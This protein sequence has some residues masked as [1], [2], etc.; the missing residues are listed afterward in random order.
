MAE[1]F[2]DRYFRIYFSHFNPPKECTIVQKTVRETNRERT[3]E[4]QHE[5]RLEGPNV[6]SRI[7][8]S[9]FWCCGSGEK[10]AGHREKK[11]ESSRFK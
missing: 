5:I 1:I 11:R 8:G 2:T 7:S 9:G 4:P 6:L 10:N 3:R